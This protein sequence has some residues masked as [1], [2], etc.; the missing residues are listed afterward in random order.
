M[1][2]MRFLV[3]LLLFLC[4]CRAERFNP[5]DPES[6]YYRN[7]ATVYGL[8][9]DWGGSPV[10]D[11]DVVLEPGPYVGISSVAGEYEITGARAG[12]YTLLATRE[13]YSAD[14]QQAQL[15]PSY[16]ARVDLTLDYLPAYTELRAT[17]H[18]DSSST[19]ND[20]YAVFFAR[21]Y[22]SDGWVLGDSVFL[23]LDSNLVWPMVQ[24]NID[25]FSVL[26]PDDSLPGGSLEY[27]VGR[28]V[29]VLATDNAGKRSVS[30]PFGIT[31]IIYQ[32]PV[33]LSPD[34]VAPQNPVTFRWFTVTGD[35]EFTYTLTV[36]E[37]WPNDNS[38]VIEGIPSNSNEYFLGVL[39]EAGMYRW[40]I[41]AVDLFGNTSRSQVLAF[42]VS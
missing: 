31:R 5:L 22:D 28:T 7:E 32:C 8:I 13:G 24:G 39:L 21:T 12:T 17:T 19:G 40:S 25:S 42:T 18:N 11:A 37:T 30:D 38:W 34:R 15:S 3:L 20:L 1:H 36:E 33:A 9:E 16:P 10:G 26:I 14:T 2:R 29:C 41:K 27:L 4:S 6:P 35:F 23:E